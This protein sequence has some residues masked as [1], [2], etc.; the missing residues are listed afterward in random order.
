[1]NARVYLCCLLRL[2]SS[3][4]VQA[5]IHTAVSIYLKELNYFFYRSLPDSVASYFSREIHSQ[6]Y[7]SSYVPK[8]ACD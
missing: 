5:L 7:R 3:Y 1:M 4:E 6:I 2:D 8:L